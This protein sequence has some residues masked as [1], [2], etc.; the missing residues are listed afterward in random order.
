MERW[1]LVPTRL[2]RQLPGRPRILCLIVPRARTR[3]KLLQR[4]PTGD[5]VPPPKI[6]VHEVD[7][8]D[9][10]RVVLS[11]VDDV[12]FPAADQSA[13]SVRT[14]ELFCL[15]QTRDG[16]GRAEGVDGARQRIEHAHFEALPPLG[17]QVLVSHPEGEVRDTLRLAVS[18]DDRLRL[19]CRV[20]LRLAG[21][22]SR[23]AKL[24]ATIL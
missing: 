14:A 7:V 11:C 13:S 10:R 17:S 18:S 16:R 20:A 24:R 6:T 5:K 3:P 9:E 19:L 12:G 4:C 2:G 8:S 1:Q 23:S 15:F 21:I 22:L